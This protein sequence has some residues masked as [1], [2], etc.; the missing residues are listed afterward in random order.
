M[1]VDDFT[2][3]VTNTGVVD[4]NFGARDISP[5]FNLSMMT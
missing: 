5:M 1:G 2:R 4:E 3:M